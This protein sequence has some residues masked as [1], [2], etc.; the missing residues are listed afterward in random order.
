[1]KYG[2]QEGCKD[3]TQGLA[4][5]VQ[6]DRHTGRDFIRASQALPNPQ[7]TLRQGLDSLTSHSWILLPQPSE[8]WD[9]RCGPLCLVRK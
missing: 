4:H 7:H 5:T 9:Q 2:K 3:P 1:M 8:S 6:G